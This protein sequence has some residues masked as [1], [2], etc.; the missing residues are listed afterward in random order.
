V[1][2]LI[3]SHVFAPRVGG[4]ETYVMFLARGL[5]ESSLRVGREKVGLT[6]AT[7]TSAGE[8][9]DSALPFGV[10][11]R[12]SLRTLWS[13]VGV[14]DV[15]Q[16]AGPAFLPLLFALLRGKPVFIEHHGYQAACPNGLL[17]YE[18]AESAC[19]QHFLARRYFKCLRCNAVTRGWLG[20]LK[21]LLLTFLRR[22]ICFRATRNITVSNHVAARLRLPH[23]Q[24][25]Y[26]GILDPGE[27][28]SSSAPTAS[29]LCFAYVGRLVR[30]K[31]LP[32]LV[33]A[34]RQLH[35]QGLAFRLKFIGDGPERPRLE[36][37]VQEADLTARTSFTG[38]LA[39]SE[40]S[41]ALDDV[42]AVV[43]P[44]IWEETAGLAAMEQMMRGRLVIAADLGGL[45]EIVDDAGL[46]FTPG[47]SGAL[48]A[49]MR[50]VIE[51][52]AL[53]ADL[54]AQARARATCLFQSDRM[55][56]DHLAAYENA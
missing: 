32:L 14:A 33:E 16:L 6:V 2:V 25:I 15:V 29:S 24:T 40:L 18:P 21:M 52:P 42:A 55:V 27:S 26:H 41:A 45:G 30:E 49:A 1:K 8:F 23:S 31:G 10:V 37:L 48:A 54:G 44:S 17:F 43:M 47:D 12:P 46:K 51:T 53:V 38:F 19:P 34:A 9:N 56:Q 5:S 39:A 20:S 28:A 4:V 13:L 35:A 50:R 22:W 3:Y 36:A 7:P 11:R